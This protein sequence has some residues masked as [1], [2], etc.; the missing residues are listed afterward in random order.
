METVVIPFV[1][2]VLL[3]NDNHVDFKTITNWL[4]LECTVFQGLFWILG[5]ISF[6]HPQGG[7][8]TKTASVELTWLRYSVNMW[9]S[10]YL[11]ETDLVQ[12]LVLKH[13]TPLLTALFCHT[14]PLLCHSGD[15]HCTFSITS[16]ATG[17]NKSGRH[18]PQPMHPYLFCDILSI[19]VALPWAK[20]QCGLAFF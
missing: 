10:W 14:H 9:R 1:V 18:H 16:Y 17:S 3:G 4:C 6:S 7:K 13:N 19:S 15:N 20:A 12:S 8:E 11:N 2:V 5:I